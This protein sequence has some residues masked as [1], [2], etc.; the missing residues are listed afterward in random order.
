MT[1]KIVAQSRAGQKKD[2]SNED[3]PLHFWSRVALTSDAQRCWNWKFTGGSHGY[4]VY[5]FKQRQWLAH[6]FAFFLTHGRI[7]RNLLVL[8]SCDN[9]KCCNPNHLRQ[10]TH[11]DNGLD[12]SK[13]GQI[14]KG[15]STVMAVLT[16]NQVRDAKRYLR[17]G[18]TVRQVFEL[19][20]I[21]TS[22]LY[23]I[24]SETAWQH[25]TV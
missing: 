17:N 1:E 18:M 25:I 21:P 2:I 14:P 19:T 10:G 5:Y 22:L 23:H 12:A 6:R 16:N 15:E 8:H 4:G 3:V 24:K 20:H 13:R 9:K 7:R 11:K